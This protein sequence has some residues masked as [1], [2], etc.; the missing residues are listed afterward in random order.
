MTPT[1]WALALLTGITFASGVL[2]VSI[3]GGSAAMKHKVYVRD[4]DPEE[5]EH[6]RAT[7]ERRGTSEAAPICQAI[8]D[9]DDRIA[10]LDT[11]ETERILDALAE[12]GVGKWWQR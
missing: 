11:D 3:Y 12:Q 2:L 5:L 9:I 10:H 4:L 7:I 1:L 6:M 8:Y